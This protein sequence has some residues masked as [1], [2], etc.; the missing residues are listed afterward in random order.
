MSPDRTA[1]VDRRAYPF[2]HR[3]V[4][5]S[6]GR[7]HY[8]EEGEG[9]PI[10]L[11]H[12][13]P[14][15]SFE[16]RHLVDGLRSRRRVIAP[17]HLGFGLSDRPAAFAYSPEAHARILRE[18]V[19]AL[20]L[21]DLTIVLHDFGGPIGLPLALDDG[22]RRVSRVVLINTWAWP[23][24]DPNMRRVARLM[25][26][27][28]GRWLYRYAN[29][30]LRVLMPSSYADR[31]R[32]TPAIHKQY[33]AP[34]RDRRARVLVLHALARALEES[35]EFYAQLANRLDRLSE[36]PVLIV[37]GMRDR[38]FPPAVLDEWRRRV[39]HATVATLPDAG[40]WPQE[41]APE[42]VLSALRDWLPVPVGGR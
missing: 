28:L 8:I 41:E 35:R 6:A 29:F 14:S 13:T 19:S 12:G 18:F 1:W 11:V 34:F 2:A 36:T 38:A 4:E 31:G 33:L 10:L 17:D 27:R 25:G 9:P 24:G 32:L 3:S 22:A 30:S 23:F 39:P 37:W 40:H 16:Y 15:W 26:G 5:T 21:E 7:L 20:D 42:A